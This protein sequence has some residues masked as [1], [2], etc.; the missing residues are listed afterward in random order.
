M[1]IRFGIWMGLYLLLGGYFSKF[2]AIGFVLWI[3][4]TNL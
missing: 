1:T 2:V 3:I 4:S